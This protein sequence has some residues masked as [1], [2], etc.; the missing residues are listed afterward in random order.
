MSMPE[1]EVSKRP[2]DELTDRLIK[3]ALEDEQRRK[4][5]KKGLPPV[6]TGP[7]TT[8]KAFKGK[9]LAEIEEEEG[10]PVKESLVGMAHTKR[11][12][13]RRAAAPGDTDLPDDIAAAEEVYEGDEEEEEEED[14]EEDEGQAGGGGRRA[15]S[16][17]GGAPAG[18]PPGGGARPAGAQ[19]GGGQAAA[20]VA[21]LPGGDAAP[22]TAFNL[23]EERG[24]GHFDEEGNFVFD[25]EDPNDQ[26]EWLRSDEVKAPVSEELRRRVEAEHAA[27]KAAEAAPALSEA[28]VARAQLEMS[29]LMQAG[30]SVAA[31]LKRMRGGGDTGPKK[32]MGKREKARLAKLEAERAAKAAAKGG[33]AG[34]GSAGGGAG[35]ASDEAGFQRLTELADMLVSAGELDVYGATCEQLRRWAALTL[36]RSEVEGEAGA[37]EDGGGKPAVDVDDDD[38]M[39]ASDDDDKPKAAAVV[40]TQPPPAAP[41][42]A[43][44]PVAAPEADSAAVPTTGAT[45]AAPPS[46]GSGGG[47]VTDYASW[48]IKELRRFLQERGQDTAGIVEKGDLVARVREAAARGPA[49]TAG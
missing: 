30:E 45:A 14:G 23:N 33:S 11:A 29:R 46:G 42:A 41:P 27:M 13:R 12:Q 39:F 17:K 1:P 40:R 25:K 3:E 9:T 31:A 48:P 32:A 47:G 21:E 34:A 35:G 8:R 24:E 19:K 22:L 37:K 36:P 44:A 10:G 6:G 16:P 7:V 28:Q 49:R 20:A 26:D 4:R 18:K 43:A 5:E 38:D 15:K 2:R